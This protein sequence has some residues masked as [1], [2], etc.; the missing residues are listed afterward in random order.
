MK[1]EKTK[2]KFFLFAAALAAVFSFNSAA[3]DTLGKS[4]VFYVDS[5]YDASGRTQISANL[6]YVSE[7]AYFY[8]DADYFNSLTAPDQSTFQNNL[9]S[10]AAVFDQTIYPKLVSVFG[11]EPNPGVDGDSRITILLERMFQS[12]GGY[13][14]N[15]NGYPKAEA[16]N[17]NEREM[18]YVNAVHLNNGNEKAFLAHEFQHLISFNQKEKIRNISEEVWMNE[19]RS[20]IAPTVAGLDEPYIG[21]NLESRSINFFNNPYDSLIDWNQSVDDY[22]SV[23][24]FGQYLL[25]RFGETVFLKMAQN[26]KIGIESV[27]DALAALGKTEKFDD[28]F[29]DFTAANFIND[30]SATPAA[31][32][33]SSVYCHSNQ[34]LKALKLSPKT[35]IAVSS[36]QPTTLQDQAIYWSN[37]G[38]KFNYSAPADKKTLVLKFDSEANANFYVPYVVKDRDG[39]NS[40]GVFSLNQGDGEISVPDFGGGNSSVL[41]M[42]FS[43]WR[44]GLPQNGSAAPRFIVTAS[45]VE[46]QNPSVSLISRIMDLTFG[47][48]KMTIS[49]TNFQSGPKVYF[50]DKEASVQFINN[51]RLEVFA[52]AAL[53]A[54][55]VN[56]SVK[57]PD[58]G[59]ASFSQLFRYLSPWQEGSLIRAKG[60][61]AVYIVK[62]KYRRHISDAKIFKMY[63][64]LGFAGVAEI[65]GDELNL[66]RESKL[67]RADG[68]LKVYEISSGKTKK[69]L[70]ITAEEFLSRGYFFDSVYI[71]NE[72]E[73]DFYQSAL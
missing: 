22:A 68:D 58:G 15:G 65:S 30:C 39:K 29:A 16:Q 20:E 14:L 44:S 31:G 69:W 24:I 9:S 32:R 18:A 38:Y 36:G 21:S 4:R 17:S 19:L 55:G 52:P 33:I 51:S 49:G 37:R 11:A 13:F 60:T 6:K 1:K 23:N 47:G 46:I 59:F 50:G 67:I 57:N 42:P 56:I 54:G 64:H 25:G 72:K 34:N 63:G 41:I 7:R 12:A 48:S 27:D 62:G 66:Y 61:S 10:L 3:A 35:T 5:Y 8:A 26:G 73:F 70:N 71:V 40:A 45:V 28:V 43:R 2:I 53:D